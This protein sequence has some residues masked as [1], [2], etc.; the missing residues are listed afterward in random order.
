MT[1]AEQLRAKGYIEGRAEDVPTVA[2]K[3]ASKGAPRT[4]RRPGIAADEHAHSQVRPPPR[5]RHSRPRGSGH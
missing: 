4:C 2:P 1:T 5:H 3:D